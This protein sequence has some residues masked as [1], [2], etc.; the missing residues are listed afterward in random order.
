M[1]QDIAKEENI[2]PHEALL[3]LVRTAT[4]RAA[5]VDTI[6][7]EQLRRHIAE[8]GDPLDPPKELK[9]WL[10][11]S[12]LERKLAATTAKQ[13]VDAGVMAALERRL[14]L[15]GELVATVLGGVLDSLDLPHDQRMAALGTA[16]QLLLEAGGP[17]A[18]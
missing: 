9:G 13:A 3:R 10:G 5:Y 1:A 2:T 11:Q 8:G 4:N 16:Q 15:E 17:A 14:D 12:R 7:T 6:I 18:T